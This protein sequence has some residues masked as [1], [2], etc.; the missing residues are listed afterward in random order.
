VKNVQSAALADVALRGF[1]PSL[2]AELTDEKVAFD[3]T[4][5]LKELPTTSPNLAFRTP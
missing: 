5:F 1:Q 3:N 2:A 4:H